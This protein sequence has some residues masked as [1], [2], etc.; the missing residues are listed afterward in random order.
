MSAS[1]RER[2]SDVSSLIA[3][4]CILSLDFCSTKWL[5]KIVF[6]NCNLVITAN[7]YI[8][9]Y[10]VKIIVSFQTRFKLDGSETAI[11]QKYNK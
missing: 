6:K 11:V 9:L 5:I 1:E 10:R 2:V 3:I 4:N 7:L 8:T